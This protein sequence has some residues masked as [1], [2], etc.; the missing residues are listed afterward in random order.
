MLWQA[1]NQDLGGIKGHPI[2]GTHTYE[3]YVMALKE[4]TAEVKGTLN[5]ADPRFKEKLLALDETADGEIG[6]ILA[7]GHLPATYTAGD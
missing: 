1:R 7:Y 2:G 3:I 6:N 5:A 4:R